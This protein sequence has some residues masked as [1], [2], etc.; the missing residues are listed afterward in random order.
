VD[1]DS[2]LMR[3]SDAHEYRQAYN[4]QAVVS[5]DGTCQCGL[6]FPQN[7]RLKIPHFDPVVVWYYRRCATVLGAVKGRALKRAPL[8][9]G[10]P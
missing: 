4:A 3:R 1:P 10:I 8:T 9:G 7:D 2:A 5:A 6:N